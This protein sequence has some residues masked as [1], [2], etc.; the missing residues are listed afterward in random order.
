MG[1]RSIDVIVAK[2]LAPQF[3]LGVADTDLHDEQ[4]H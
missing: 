2:W 4:K 3:L 1:D